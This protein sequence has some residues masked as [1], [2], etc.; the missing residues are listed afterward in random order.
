MIF[1]AW[2]CAADPWAVSGTGK[3]PQATATNHPVVEE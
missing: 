1:R 3:V 2:P